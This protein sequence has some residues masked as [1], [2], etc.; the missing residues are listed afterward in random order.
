MSENDGISKVI[1]GYRHFREE[2]YPEH[3]ELFEA[4]QKPAES[5]GALHHLRR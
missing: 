2:V 5:S 3:R 4:A 1:E